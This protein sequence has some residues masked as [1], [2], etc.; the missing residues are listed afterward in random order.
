MIVGAYAA[1]PTSRAEQEAFLS[2]IADF[3]TGLEI[4]W[5]AGALDADP[6]WLA[7]Q[8]AGRFPD[9][10]VTAIP[11]T[12]RMQ[13][14]NPDFGLA[15]PNDAGRAAALAQA[16]E[17]FAAIATLNANAGQSVVTRVELHSAPSHTAD[18]DA[19]VAS[20][21]ELAP[22]AERIGVEIVLEHCD[23]R[24]G[25]GVGEK[26]FLSL[27]EEIDAATRAGVK[28]TLNWGRTVIESHDPELPAEQAALLAERDLL[29]GLMCSG[30]GG[31]DTGYGVGWADT[32]LPLAD[33]EPTSLLTED[34]VRGFIGAGG[35]REDYRG[36]KIQVPAGADVQTR[37][38]MIRRLAAMC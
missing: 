8:L 25:A 38:A 11:D 15:S 1:M 33:D 31:V 24:G 17:I 32:H 3:A 36:V 18:V 29:A 6:G 19:L 21:T 7:T 20:L 28:I 16:R 26:N 9:C 22:E 27:A 5:R 13:G 23:A 12:M 4:P 30:A 14:Q 35:G 34:R 10:V 37:A 2:A